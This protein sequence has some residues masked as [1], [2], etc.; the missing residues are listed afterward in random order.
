M[1]NY[2][3]LY[4]LGLSNSERSVTSAGT[5]T[6]Q[7]KALQSIGGGRAVLDPG[8]NFTPNFKDLNG[9]TL[10]G[11]AIEGQGSGGDGNAPSV[12]TPTDVTSA[13]ND[14]AFQ[15]CVF[16]N[17]VMNG[18]GLNAARTGFLAG[19]NNIYNLFDNVWWI[20][21]VPQISHNHGKNLYVRGGGSRLVTAGLAGSFV[22][23]WS[24]PLGPFYLEDY[25]CDTPVGAAG[26]AGYSQVPTDSWYIRGLKFG[27]LNL[28]PSDGAIDCEGATAGPPHILVTGSEI[29]NAKLYIMTCDSAEVT[30]SVF[31]RTTLYNLAA[32]KMITLNGAG[33]PA[34]LGSLKIARC[35][36]IDAVWGSNQALIPRMLDLTRDAQSGPITL[37]DLHLWYSNRLTSGT[38]AQRCLIDLT[39]TSNLSASPPF[40]PIR[41][42]GIRF[43]CIENGGTILNAIIH[44]GASAN[45]LGAWDEVSIEDVA[46][47]LSGGGPTLNIPATVAQSYSFAVQL[48]NAGITSLIAKVLIERL[49]A[50]NAGTAPIFEAG[51]LSN[52]VR[53][54]RRIL[55]LQNSGADTYAAVGTGVNITHGTTNLVTSAKPAYNPATIA[56][57]GGA[58]VTAVVK[59]GKTI[60]SQASGALAGVVFRV[61]VGD[62]FNVVF[63]T[64]FPPATVVF[65][66]NGD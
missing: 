50:T 24:G 7:L 54:Y 34:A 48:G 60:Y 66:T 13:D 55:P 65:D 28:Y 51:T 61:N 57:V 59:N 43:G 26:F 27:T 30:D 12:I 4:A 15:Y 47:M 17:L 14:Y 9:L 36:F 52:L 62:T 5:L 10:K 21:W 39:A 56:L 31:R 38:L 33:T 23:R 8:I 18:A 40:G 20:D 11:I 35:S 41:I 42:R 63:A 19:T 45:S 37:E 22:G 29:V 58:G 16:R 2:R 25:M 49:R 53:F 32:P 3:S 64:T 6:A 44:L 1:A 46:E